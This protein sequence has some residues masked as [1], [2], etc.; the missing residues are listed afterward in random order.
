MDNSSHC[1]VI[2]EADAMV[3]LGVKGAPHTL[4]SSGEDVIG[5]INYMLCD[6]L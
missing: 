1:A 4:L 5:E 2:R 3:H 6:T